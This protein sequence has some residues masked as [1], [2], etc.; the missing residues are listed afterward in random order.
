M[1]KKT[2]PELTYDT[3][4]HHPVATVF[5]SDG[6]LYMNK[7]AEQV[8]GYT[9]DQFKSIEDWFNKLSAADQKEA[10][11]DYLKVKNSSSNQKKI[12][13]PVVTKNSEKKIF[14]LKIENH[15]EIEIWSL[16]DITESILT[17]LR[18]TVLF[19]H[20]S[21]PHLLFDENGIT[22]CNEATLKILNA[23]SKNEIL[24]A[25][26]AVFSPEYQPCGTKSL[27]KNKLMDA[28]AKEKGFHR[29]E[30]VHKKLTG[31]EFLVDVTLSPV[32]VA[33]KKYLL[34]VWHDLT[35][36][37]QAQ[38]AMMSSAKLAT[39]GEMAANISH[40]INNPLSIIST[41]AERVA[42]VL[43]QLSSLPPEVENDLKIIKNTVKR[44]VKI[45]SGLKSFS[46]QSTSDFEKNVSVLACINQAVDLC[47]EKLRF[48][49]V[50][51]DLDENVD[52]HL[53]A[54]SVQITQ[55]ILNLISN[56]YDAIEN[57][58]E[59][60][61]K[62]QIEK[63]NDLILIRVTDSGLGIPDNIVDNIMKPFFTTKEVGKGTGLGL[64][65]SYGIINAH[66]G[67]FYYDKS[68][69]NTSFVIELPHKND[70]N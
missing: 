44:A 14:D 37:R 68:C 8:T 52:F 47:R 16:E 70:I 36:V 21:D 3:L 54:N 28:A 40:E 6:Q 25:H 55:V 9:S 35:E 62:I 59:K 58:T 22:D 46:R 32:T 24:S 2:C 50:T 19:N 66:S 13:L 41:R 23:K 60:W 10:Y 38:S 15:K 4:M 51:L 1:R 31:E 56:S 11:Q 20:S 42:K 61:I 12:R 65:I 43:A 48:S 49:E 34:V 67:R 30:W 57:Q 64:S 17:E 45:I 63:Q 5:I 69:K 18:F 27:E 33:D 39:L 29:F 26:P 7:K 53:T